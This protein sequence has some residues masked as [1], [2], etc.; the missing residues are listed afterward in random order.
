MPP[1]SDLTCEETSTTTTSTINI[2]A[3]RHGSSVSNEWMT[4]SNAWFSPTFCDDIQLADSPLS[5]TG[6]AQ[7]QQ[8]LPKELQCILDSTNL[9]D[10]IVLVSPLMRC[11]QT[12]FYGVQPLLPSVPTM[13]VPLLRE[14]IYS[15]S[16]TGQ[17]WGLLQNK[18]RELFTKDIAASLDWSLLQDSHAVDESWWYTI[19]DGQTPPVEWRPCDEQQ[20]YAVPGEPEDVFRERLQVLEEWLRREFVGKTVVL[21][22]HW[23]VLHH[24]TQVEVP[25]CGICQWSFHD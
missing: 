13:I 25:N 3:I 17:P 10:V 22:T 2:I 18:C 19:P 12:W 4:G 6:I 20:H 21:V 16:D 23:G 7:A 15:A 8:E 9:D 11:L 24:F 14:R 5:E 1:Q